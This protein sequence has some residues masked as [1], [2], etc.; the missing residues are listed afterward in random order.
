MRRRSRSR[1]RTSHASPK[2]TRLSSYPTPSQSSHQSAS[3]YPDPQTHIVTLA[4]TRHAH[5]HT[6]THTDMRTHAQ[7]RTHARTH[8]QPYSAHWRA[9]AHLEAHTY[10]MP[11]NTP[12][13]PHIHTHQQVYFPLVLGSRRVLC[14]IAGVPRRFQVW[15][16]LGGCGV[17]G[18]VCGEEGACAWHSEG[19]NYLCTRQCNRANTHTHTH[20]NTHTFPTGV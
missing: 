19:K 5:T 3:T 7:I 11:T 13:H 2:S 15:D 8:I 12:T 10:H 16:W 9:H 14:F 17:R 20:T 6:R 1:T 18:C 4:H